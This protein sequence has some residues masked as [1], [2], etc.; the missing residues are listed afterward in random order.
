[1]KIALI[2]S[3]GIPANYGGF[4]TF[5][6]ELSKRLVNDFNHDVIVVCDNE[7]RELNRGKEVLDGVKLIYS[8]YSKSKNAILYYYDSITLALH[9]SDII[10]SCGPAGALF[11]YLV[12]RQDKILITNP[13]GLNY[14][15]AK[16]SKIVQKAFKWFDYFAS[17][18]SDLVL[19]DSYG[20]EKYIK[21]EYNPKA[22]AVIEYGAYPNQFIAVENPKVESVLNRYNLIPHKYHL[23]VS[24]LEPEN[25][26]EMII[27]G[28]KKSSREYPLIIIGN[29]NKYYNKLKKISNMSILFLGGVYNSDELSIIRANALDYLH[30]HSVGGT[31]PSLLEAMASKNITICHDNN[32]NREVAKDGLFFKNSDELD[33]ILSKIEEQPNRYSNQIDELYKRIVL[34]YNWG[35]IAKRY[36]KLFISMSKND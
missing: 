35:S 12:Y 5:V 11:G 20:I 14:K 10:Y 31:N 18:N 2:G 21:D 17:K 25:H 34:Y 8:K 19:C 33:M 3:R 15:R 22:T 24:R 1:M 32:F 16:W 4:E 7:Q 30:G 26:L 23:V 13:D 29:K 27:K 28:Y 6:D 9:H 36:D